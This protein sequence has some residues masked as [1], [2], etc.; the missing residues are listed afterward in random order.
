[1]EF[2]LQLSLESES[3]HYER[4]FS[5]LSY[6][7]SMFMRRAHVC[8]VGVGPKQI[9]GNLYPHQPCLIVYVTEKRPS[10]DID[11]RDYIPPVFR[12]VVTDVVKVGSR[13]L[14]MHNEFDQRWLRC[15][16]ENPAVKSG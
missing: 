1:M 4:C 10:S 16:E 3:Q 9:N 15:G 12:G 8:G 13:D 5:R 2:K 7:R 6:A 14:L 11:H